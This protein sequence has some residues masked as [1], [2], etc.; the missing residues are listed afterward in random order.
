MRKGSLNYKEN[1]FYRNLLYFDLVVPSAPLRRMNICMYVPLFTRCRPAH[2]LAKVKD[3]DGHPYSFDLL[4]AYYF[5][6]RTLV[7]TIS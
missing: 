7:Q 4:S 1:P 6:S 5:C 2:V 3:A